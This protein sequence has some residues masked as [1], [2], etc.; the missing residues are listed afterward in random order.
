MAGVV[1]DLIG[2]STHA[3]LRLPSLMGRN[4]ERPEQRY[5]WHGGD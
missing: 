4:G 2:L 1:D 3:S 5:D